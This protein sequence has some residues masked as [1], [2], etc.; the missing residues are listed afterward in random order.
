MVALSNAWADSSSGVQA[1]GA[2]TAVGRGT[3]VKAKP[4]D[5][6]KGLDDVMTEFCVK[7][8]SG[9][10]KLLHEVPQVAPHRGKWTQV[11]YAAHLQTL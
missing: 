10:W 4:T 6:L 11:G 2:A 3:E 7:D 1:G 8:V 5:T 9:Q